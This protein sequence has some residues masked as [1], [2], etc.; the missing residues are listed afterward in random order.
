MKQYNIPNYLTRDPVAS[1]ADNDVTAREGVWFRHEGDDWACYDAL[2]PAIRRRLQAHAYDPWAANAH[3]L[4]RD[5]RRRHA[6]SAR[7]ERALLRHF[8]RCERDERSA[9]DAAYRAAHGGP[10]PHIA[11]GATV[12]RP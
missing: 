2:P 7:A 9:F 3:L 12:Q 1:S 11:A 10:L 6:S 5:F 4:W 8:D